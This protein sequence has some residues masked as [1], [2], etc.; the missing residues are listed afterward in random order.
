M[1]AQPSHHELHEGMP[2]C[3]QL[4]K[5][6]NLK[7]ISHKLVADVHNCHFFELFLWFDMR[8]RIIQARNLE[9]S[10]IFNMKYEWISM[11]LEYFFSTNLLFHVHSE[12]I[13]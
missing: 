13:S 8:H 9:G 7:E 1:E 5:T 3:V 6:H 11:Y 10:G 4:Y 2:I 12:S